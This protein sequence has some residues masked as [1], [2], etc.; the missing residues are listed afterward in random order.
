MFIE[1]KQKLRLPFEVACRLYSP[2][3]TQ[4][5]LQLMCSHG[6]WFYV[7]DS[8][9]VCVVCTPTL[10]VF[11]TGIMKVKYLMMSSDKILSLSQ[12]YT[13]SGNILCI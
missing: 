8:I 7:A 12:N 2:L 4:L 9:I 1:R 5:S 13:F 3:E 11:P 10:V 6:P